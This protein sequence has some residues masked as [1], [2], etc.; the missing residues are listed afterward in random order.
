VELDE[1][2]ASTAPAGE[3]R[4]P[5]RPERVERIRPA[6]VVARGL[7]RQCE[8]GVDATCREVV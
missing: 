5:S 1:R 3:D 2:L 8:G 6:E 7:L 4:R